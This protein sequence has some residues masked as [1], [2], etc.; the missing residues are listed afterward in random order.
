MYYHLFEWLS[1]N[2][3]F[4]TGFSD[5]LQVVTTNYYNSLTELHV[6][7]I[8]VTTAHIKYSLHSPTSNWELNS[9]L[10]TAPVIT[11][12]H[13]PQRK[14]RSSVAVQLLL[15]KNLLRPLPETNVVSE[16]FARNGCFSGSTVLALSKYATVSSGGVTIY[17][18]PITNSPYWP[19]SYGLLNVQIVPIFFWTRATGRRKVFWKPRST[20]NCVIFTGFI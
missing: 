18:Y 10:Q 20:R 17:L 1:T 19:L 7:N 11:S 4:V 8:T 5:H 13:G 12:W 14:Y 6:P 3:G 2:F 16:P 15:I 9:L